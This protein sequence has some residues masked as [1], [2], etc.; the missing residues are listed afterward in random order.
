MPARLAALLLA[1]A[2][3]R[4]EAPLVVAA[5]SLS[6]VVPQVLALDA[7]PVARASFAASSTLARQVERGLDA[8]VFV[9][10]DRAWVD[11]LRERGIGV[12][13]APFATN[14]LVAWVRAGEPAPN[15]VANLARARRI[16][17]GAESVP[18]GRY[19]REALAGRGLDD[20]LLPCRDAP[21]VLAAL[22]A[23][24]A[25]VAIAYA[26]D[27]DDRARPAFALDSAVTYWA[28]QC[29]DRPEAARLFDLLVS[30]RARAILREAGFR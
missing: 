16:A 17:V 12:R 14:R 29:R 18:V 8:D 19:A 2:C 7:G 4:G 9:S 26:T 3:S 24:E 25:D 28:L 1:A 5:A 30:E 23:G 11:H 6:R 22:L 27:G 20:R 10:A 13:E 21:A 15:G